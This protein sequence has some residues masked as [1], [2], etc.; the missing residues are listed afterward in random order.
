M[1]LSR[2]KT[3]ALAALVFIAAIGTALLKGRSDGK[4]AAR[5][6]QQADIAA[7]AAKA[8]KEVHDVEVDVASK[9]D[10]AADKQLR[11]DWMRD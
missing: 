7:E 11:D 1:I 10:G 6:Q 3:W 8:Q 2:L 9:P 5:N 4:K